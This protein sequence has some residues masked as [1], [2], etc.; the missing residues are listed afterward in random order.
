M[1]QQA[2]D[3]AT[4]IILVVLPELQEKCVKA[5]EESVESYGLDTW[6]WRPWIV[7]T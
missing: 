7:G 3:Q 2:R 1:Y 5:L 4:E 6:D